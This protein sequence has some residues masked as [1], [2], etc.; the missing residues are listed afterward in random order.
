MEVEAATKIQA[1][2][3]GYKVRKELK[4]R[5]SSDDDITKRPIRRKSSGRVNSEP[6]TKSPKKQQKENLKE[7]LVEKSAVKIQ[8]G[9]RGFLVRRRQK[10]S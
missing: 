4:L 2:F 1:G 10:K 7:D 3:R 5:D 9:V 6:N 8:A